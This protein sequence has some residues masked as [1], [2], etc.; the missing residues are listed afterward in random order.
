MV[1]TL[2]LRGGGTWL[3]S[4]SPTE[5]KKE[6]DKKKNQRKIRTDWKELQID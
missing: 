6:K 2:E 4:T 3:F 1:S 5:T